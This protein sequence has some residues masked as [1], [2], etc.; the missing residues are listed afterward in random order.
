MVLK[1]YNFTC[2]FDENEQTCP[3]NEQD[4]SFNANSSIEGT[5]L[6][7]KSTT[8]MLLTIVCYVTGDVICKELLGDLLL[9]S[10]DLH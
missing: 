1:L 10:I 6:D 9:S 4:T 2:P 3:Q 5:R 7:V 8:I